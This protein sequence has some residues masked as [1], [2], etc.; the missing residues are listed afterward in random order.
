MKI[1]KKI[2]MLLIKLIPNKNVRR[3]LRDRFRKW[4]FRKIINS[5]ENGKLKKELERIEKEFPK[6][7]SF[8]ETIDEIIKYKR[9]ISRFGDGEFN[10]LIENKNSKNVFQ[11]KSERLK[12]KLE[13]ILKNDNPN[14]LV[15]II[16]VRC[17]EK[18]ENKDISKPAA[19]F[20]ELYWLDK[21]KI[22]K[23]YFIK[24]KKYGNA[25]ISRVAV[26]SEVKLE[27]IKKIWENREIVFVYSQKGR[28]NLDERLFN[29][30]KNYDE[31]F[32]PPINAFDNYDEI[33][34]EC[35]KKEKN[36]LFLISAGPTATILAYDL[37]LLGYQ[38]IDIGHFPNS[39]Q[40]YLGEIILPE[41]LPK[42]KENKEGKL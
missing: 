5:I 24:N 25:A 35:K 9:S 37:S 20:T 2:I 11:E 4:Y 38:A 30:I 39:Y 23:K 26:F 17:A 27:K 7:L 15:C 34:N 22:L 13:D 41:F 36:K 33:L 6:V 19:Y 1:L 3:D 21:W 40:Q 31:I 18:K 12:N 10:L 32:I 28:F 8:E 14:L 29:N 16:R 42:I